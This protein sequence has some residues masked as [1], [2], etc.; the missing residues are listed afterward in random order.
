LPRRDRDQIVALIVVKPPLGHARRIAPL[1]H[2]A[3]VRDPTEQILALELEQE[4]NAARRPAAEV[5]IAGERRGVCAIDRQHHEVCHSILEHGSRRSEPRG[6]LALAADD[7]LGHALGIELGLQ[8]LIEILGRTAVEP[9]RR[10]QGRTIGHVPDRLPTRLNYV[11]VVAQVA[12]D[13]STGCE[14]GSRSPR[15]SP[16][17]RGTRWTRSRR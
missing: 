3:R 17:R 8:P 4:L 16:R 12:I 1:R 11:C 13:S 7:E 2:G 9:G 15:P 5:L 6:Q 14:P 10:S